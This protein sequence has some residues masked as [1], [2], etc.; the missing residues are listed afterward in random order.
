MLP[1]NQ[2]AIFTAYNR[3]TLHPLRGNVGYLPPVSNPSNDPYPP[4][5]PSC[6]LFDT[7]VR[8]PNR[9]KQH[10]YYHHTTMLYYYPAWI[11]ALLHANQ[12]TH[13]QPSSIHVSKSKCTLSQSTTVTPQHQHSITETR[14]PI[15]TVLHNLLTFPQAWKVC[16]TL[17]HT[18]L[19][20]QCHCIIKLQTPILPTPPTLQLSQSTSP[21]DTLILYVSDFHPT[22]GVHVV[23]MCCS[24]ESSFGIWACQ[25][26]ERGT[27]LTRDFW[28]YLAVK[29]SG[30]ATLLYNHLK[31]QH[32]SGKG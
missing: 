26:G 22:A 25:S 23:R 10:L 14:A 4:F 20:C 3:F 6:C 1:A 30:Q 28:L 9:P 13:P 12:R 5:A 2:V 32:L 16:T 7:F 27:P 29:F 24:A 31:V 8:H 18:F 21:S 17:Q 19:T 15:A 11:C